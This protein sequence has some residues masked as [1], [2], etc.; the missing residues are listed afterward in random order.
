VTP[1]R[2]LRLGEDLDHAGLDRDTGLYGIVD[3]GTP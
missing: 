2:V 1:A 3:A